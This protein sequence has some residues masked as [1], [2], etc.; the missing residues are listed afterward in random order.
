MRH[1]TK[2]RGRPRVPSDKLRDRPVLL[3]LDATEKRTFAAA[4][5]LAGIPLSA[6]MRERLRRAASHELAEPN[7]SPFGQDRGVSP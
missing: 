4:A 5:D 6:W 3:R 7:R 2:K 1:A